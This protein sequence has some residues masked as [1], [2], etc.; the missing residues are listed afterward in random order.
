M[1]Q[2]SDRNREEK[3]EKK[4]ISYRPDQKEMED[5]VA[6]YD[7][8]LRFRK[9][10][11]IA[12]CVVLAMCIIL[13]LFHIYTAGFGILPEW[14]HRSFHLTF[15]LALIFLAYPTRKSAVRN[16]LLNLI[17]DVLFSATMAM[18]MTIS[19]GKV[20][21]LQPFSMVF[22]FGLSFMLVLYMKARDLTPHA[23]TPILD[24]LVSLICL[25]LLG[26]AYCSI[27]LNWEEF[28]GPSGLPTVVWL[29]IILGAM[30]ATCLYMAIDSLRV[31][32]GRKEYRFDPDRI[33][34]FEVL[35]A[36]MAFAV[37]SFLFMDYEQ[38]MLRAGM[39][40]TRDLIFGCFIL[41][42]LIEGTRR[43]IGPQLAI[44][45]IAMLAYAY[46]GPLL[47]DIPGLK[48][49][50]HRGYSAV[51]ITEHMYLG[52]EGI[53]GIPLGVV[54]TFVFHF[55]LFGIFIT[56]TGLGQ[57]F[58]DLATALAG[59]SKGGP[60]KVS[61]VA[62]GFLGMISG[63]S[64][65]NTVT[66]GAFTI[67]MMKRI[68]YKPEF[69][70]A[71][72]AAAST[73]GQ[74]MP[75]IM[76]AAAFIMAEFLAIPYIKIVACAV[77]PAALHF[78]SVATMVH[79]QAVKEG[80]KGIPREEL[81]K[82]LPI[83][84]DKGLNFVPLFL[85]V[86]LL[87]AGFSPF[88]A[89]F[90]GIINST[91]LGQVSRKTSS[92]MVAVF[93]SLPMILFRWDPFLAPDA[94]TF[95]WIAAM[96]AGLWWSLRRSE[97][98]HWALGTS[99]VVLMI[100]LLLLD[101]EPSFAAFWLNLCIIAMGIFYKESKMRIP[102]LVETLEWGTKNALA[103]G[104]AC[105]C[106][107]FVVGTATLT[108]LGI[109]FAS[110]AVQLSSLSAQAIKHLD[111]TGILQMDP[112][113]F[114]FMLLYAAI[115]CLIL[116][117]GL[118]TTPAYIIMAI[119]AA[120]AL[121]KFG[122]PALAT[123]MFVFYFGLSADITPPV[124][125]AAYAASGIS[126]GEPFKTGVTAFYLSLAK[127]YV[128]FAFVYSPIIL[129]LPWLLDPKAT[130]DFREFFI[131]IIPIIAG[132]ISL[133]AVVIGCMVDRLTGLERILLLIATILLFIH[134]FYT[135]AFGLFLLAA[136]YV[137]QKLF[138]QRQARLEMATID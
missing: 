124:A 32:A 122:V 93:I 70:G 115:G 113:V 40:I 61:V 57:L 82:A 73:G 136:V 48:L 29:F 88:L 19:L 60:A 72:E 62:S 76:G 89:A 108:G 30:T 47:I 78:F 58:I 111:F 121:L 86:Y 38:F 7:P 54:A 21:A 33:P 84:W 68:G 25:G 100:V 41:L 26:Y 81:P 9:L 8:E 53:Y 109:K 83:I 65:A 104:A 46:L 36:I 64:I 79:F 90:W 135:S 44:I 102:Q 5:L 74:I 23:V 51:R 91:S 4:V 10:K 92:F 24:L 134:E 55:V 16:K 114:F 27:F 77:I 96:A 69:A 75:P 120:P 125:L 11:G 85:I 45:G 110:A 103:V 22:V 20:L 50:A 87:M 34:L 67:P 116:G 28:V 80:L 2:T 137:K 59:W 52:T 31:L 118:P 106:V 130:F 3:E 63:S 117:M 71:V 129:L 37:S 95:L 35:L 94:W 18:I 112:L 15:V 123:H 42:L 39:P 12:R 1:G 43:S 107:G 126:G 13:S 133:G 132:V 127:T 131:V 56:K 128:P 97:I 99:T 49:F 6:I 138:V 101:V 105:A 17:Y 98:L 14:R 66:T 119:I